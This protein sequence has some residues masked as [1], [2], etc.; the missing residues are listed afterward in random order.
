M[1]VLNIFFDPKKDYFDQVYRSDPGPGDP[2][3]REYSDPQT[4]KWSGSTT[5]TVNISYEYIVIFMGESHET[6]MKK[7]V[8]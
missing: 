5:G 2:C 7:R 3:R 8:N 6:E 1:E 4:L